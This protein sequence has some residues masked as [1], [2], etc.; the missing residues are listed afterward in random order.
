MVLNSSFVETE[1]TTSPYHLRV[2]TPDR[3]QDGLG[4]SP[5]G[6]RCVPLSLE[7]QNLGDLEYRRHSPRLR[8]Q[9]DDGHEIPGPSVD[10]S[11]YEAG[12]G[13]KRRRHDRQPARLPLFRRQ[14]GRIDKTDCLLR[15]RPGQITVGRNRHDAINVP[16]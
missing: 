4:G 16:T 3:D 7:V 12:D 9:T 8:P 5:P 1:G 15:E 11:N 2:A 14:S 13:G 6:P 10:L